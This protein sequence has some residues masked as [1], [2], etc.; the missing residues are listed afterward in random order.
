MSKFKEGDKVR[1]FKKDTNMRW[2]WTSNM[3]KYVGNIYVIESVQKNG[4]IYLENGYD[5]ED[6]TWDK[7]VLKLIGETIWRDDY[8][9]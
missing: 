4:S 5:D 6:Y 9:D 2:G 3:D 8:E 1:V 7:S